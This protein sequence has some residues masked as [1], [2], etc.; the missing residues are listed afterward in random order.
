MTITVPFRDRLS[1]DQRRAEFDR[2]RTHLSER[3]PIVVET[4]GTDTPRVDREKFLVP[5]DLTVAQFSFVIRKRMQ[6]GASRAI[7]L[8]VDDVLPPGTTVVHE[9]YDRH[10][11]EDGF[12]YVVCTTE[13]TFG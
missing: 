2:I 11:S 10:A 8:L 3:V 1:L 9:L 5:L 6:L 12:L 4:R 13:N 7:F